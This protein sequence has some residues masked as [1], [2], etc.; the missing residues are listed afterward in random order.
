MHDSTLSTEEYVQLFDFT[1]ST[2]MNGN[3]QNSNKVN[4]AHN[5]NKNDDENEKQVAEIYNNTKR[6]KIKQIAI[7]PRHPIQSVTLTIPTNTPLHV[8]QRLHD[9]AEMAGFTSI[10]FKSSTMSAAITLAQLRPQLFTANKSQKSNKNSFS[11][12]N[13]SAGSGN[14]VNKEEEKHYSQQ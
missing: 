11:S 2:S 10:D 3:S 1:K 12:Y 5:R 14:V 4:H 8:I 13:N 9:A 6:D 7:P